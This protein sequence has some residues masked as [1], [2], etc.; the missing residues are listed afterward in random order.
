M[1]AIFLELALISSIVATTCGH[2]LAAALR[3]R[4]GRAGE[5]VGGGCR[6]R[7]L[8]HVPVSCSIEVAVCCRLARRLLG[9]G[10]EVLLP[11][12]IS[13]DAVAI[14]SATCCT[15]PSTVAA[16]TPSRRARAAGR[17]SRRAPRC[18]AARRPAGSDLRRGVAGGRDIGHD[19]ALREPREA[20]RQQ[21]RKQ[22]ECADQRRAAV[23]G[24]FGGLPSMAARACA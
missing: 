4:G 7:A 16:A 15:L 9:A 11:L 6:V 23:R 12:A 14:D 20:H 17:R 24:G 3:D 22:A 1:S 21:H 10:G 2:D 19:A 18:A 8:A 5:L 13:F